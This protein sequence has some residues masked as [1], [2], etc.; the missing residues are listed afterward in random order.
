MS[1]EGQPP[2]LSQGSTSLQ[3]PSSGVRGHREKLS[4]PAALETQSY[5]R[6]HGRSSSWS[7]FVS[8]ILPSQRSERAQTLRNAYKD[9][10]SQ[11]A[12][13]L[14]FGMVGFPGSNH[15]SGVE[16]SKHTMVQS[17]KC[18][19]NPIDVENHHY[20]SSPPDGHG[21]SGPHPSG[22]TRRDVHATQLNETERAQEKKGSSL[23]R[24]FSSRKHGKKGEG[25][26]L[27][28]Y[29]VS[30]KQQQAVFDLPLLSLQRENSDH[31]ESEKKITQ[32]IFQDKKARREQRKNLRESGDFLGVQGANPRTGYWDVSTA[33]SSSD[34]SQQSE[35]TRR[36]IEQQAKEVGEQKRKYEEAQAKHESELARMQTLRDKEKKDRTNQKAWESK[37]K[38]RRRGKWKLSEN[39]WS[40]VAEPDLS[41]IVQ[42]VAGSPTRGQKFVQ[43]SVS[44]LFKDS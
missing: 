4:P 31:Q 21:S 18:S 11:V 44:G 43:A 8:R 17:T 28:N 39:G 3:C 35:E 14:V 29:A 22:S 10:G 36:K 27:H 42:S 5:R 20:R 33:T 37:I 24:L 16:R 9:D 25:K 1:M 23:G 41:P 40:S 26:H 6:K 7:G 30:P 12:T 38:Q 19:Q 2:S 34:P 15:S 13:D 32:Q